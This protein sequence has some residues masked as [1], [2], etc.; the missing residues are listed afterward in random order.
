MSCSNEIRRRKTY[1]HTRRLAEI[2]SGLTGEPHVVYMEA[3]GVYGQCPESGYSDSK[4]EYV[5]TVRN[6]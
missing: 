4:G 2:C 3:E 1:E 5:E 6:S